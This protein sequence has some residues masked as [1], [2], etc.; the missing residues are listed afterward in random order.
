MA[1]LLPSPPHPS[2][3]YS[4]LSVDQLEALRSSTSLAL[5]HL[6][7]MLNM[8]H[9]GGESAVA[10]WPTFLS[11]YQKMQRLLAQLNHHLSVG[12]HASDHHDGL[13]GSSIP[14]SSTSRGSL[15]NRHVVHPYIPA[16]AA[17]EPWLQ[18]LLMNEPSTAATSS[19]TEHL[20]AT[21]TIEEHEAR[22][23]RATR[24]CG[25]LVEQHDWRGRVGAVKDE[26]EDNED[27]EDGEGDEDEDEDEDGDEDG[28][29][30]ATNATEREVT[31]SQETQ[32]LGNKTK[33]GDTTEL[34]VAGNGEADAEGEEEGDPESD[35]VRKDEDSKPSENVVSVDAEMVDVRQEDENVDE[36]DEDDEDED[37]FGDKD[38]DM[39]NI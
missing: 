32:L 12:Q 16:D 24:I 33:P 9:W 6:E 28:D 22:R 20:P 34:A 11:S 29:G 31:A 5:V 10:G 1:D 15:L 30:K 18:T 8:L 25:L 19:S 17:A 37:I 38:D 39:S 26:D 23:Q 27:A 7:E 14:S 36:D 13:L 21:G 4:S 2:L 3:Q 35:T